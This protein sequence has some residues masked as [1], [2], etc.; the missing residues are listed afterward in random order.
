MVVGGDIRVREIRDQT[1]SRQVKPPASE[2]QAD[3]ESWVTGNRP[4]RDYQVA[5]VDHVSS[6]AQ[7][8]AKQN[9]PL[10]PAIPPVLRVIHDETPEELEAVSRRT[11]DADTADLQLELSRQLAAGAS[12]RMVEPIRKRAQELIE[13]LDESVQR[14]HAR[15]VLERVEQYQRV[16]RRRDGEPE[17]KEPAPVVN[18]QAS[19]GEEGP[20]SD[21]VRTGYLVQVYS[22]RP[23]AP[24]Y[25]INDASG[26][27]LAYVSPALGVRLRGYLN[28]HVGLKGETKF[29]TGLNTPHIIASQAVPVRR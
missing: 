1:T 19:S 12:A 24:P 5:T 7:E 3:D 28:R 17:P 9:S 2:E 20:P 14:G 21:F 10:Q 23:Q 26:R 18:V 15:L 8:G 27:T 4:S 25:A 22:A 16:A 29:D 6:L 11:I 13:T